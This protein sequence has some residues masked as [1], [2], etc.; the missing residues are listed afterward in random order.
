VPPYHPDVPEVRG[1][2]ARYYDNLTLMDEELGGRLREVQEAGLM[3]DTIVF[4]FGD[5]GSGMPRHKR[6]AMDSGLRVPLIVYVPEKFK[7]LAPPDYAMGGESDRLVSFVDFGPTVLSLAGIRAP[8][9]MQGRAFAGEFAQSPHEYLFGARGRMDSRIDLV[10][11]VTD[12]RYVYVRNY[13]P[14]LPHGQHLAYQMETATTRVWEQMYREGKLNPVQAYFWGPKAP[15]ELY[16]LESDPDEIENLARDE[17]HAETLARLNRVLDEHLIDIRDV[18]FAPEPVLRALPDGEAPYTF[19]HDDTRYPL[20]R[21]MET[22]RLAAALRG[23]DLPELVRRAG[24]SNVVIRYWAAL[25]IY[26]RGAD[27]AGAVLDTFR[28]L[29]TDTAPVVRVVAAQALANYGNADDLAPA[30]ETL[31]GLADAS[32]NEI[33]LAAYALNALDYLDEK[34]RRYLDRIKTLPAEDTGAQPRYRTYVP[35]ILEKTLADLD[36]RSGD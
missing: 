2:W 7:H 35:R 36:R 29:S 16:D 14:H 31:L 3:D 9:Y 26:M 6:A 1:D 15:E 27:V 12:G 5:H 10:R 33:T 34:A 22:A 18:D 17:E 32:K 30:M 23:G 28:T 11:T 21:I 8:D 24:D 19:G 13:M 20:A 4:Y 25:G